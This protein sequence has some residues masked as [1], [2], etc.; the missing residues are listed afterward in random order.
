MTKVRRISVLVRDIIFKAKISETV[1]ALGAEMSS[2]RDPAAL[3]QA[4]RIEAPDLVVIDISVVWPGQEEASRELLNGLAA[5][6]LLPASFGF[7]SHVEADAFSFF[8]QNGLRV[9]PR[10]KSLSELSSRIGA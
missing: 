9:V 7:V 3:I 6:G 2:F 4:A 8:D 5:M 1:K 10:S